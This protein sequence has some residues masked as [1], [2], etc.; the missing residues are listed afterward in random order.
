MHRRLLK[1]EMWKWYRRDIILPVLIVTIIG[2]TARENF[3]T[4]P[5]QL[6]ILLVILSTCALAFVA[7][8]WA[9]GNLNSKSLS[10]LRGK[11]SVKKYR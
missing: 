11:N 4:D 3:P 6:V 7:S 5:S 2:V 8:A 1:K 9:T 10:L